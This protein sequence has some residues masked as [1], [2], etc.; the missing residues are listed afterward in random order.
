MWQCPFENTD[1]WVWVNLS[2]WVLHTNYTIL[3]ITN[4]GTLET[5]SVLCFNAA[6]VLR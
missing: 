5:P 3:K 6:K 2:K 4:E 1:I